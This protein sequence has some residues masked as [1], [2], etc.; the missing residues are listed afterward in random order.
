MLLHEGA[1]A[2]WFLIIYIIIRTKR[3]HDKLES[4][5]SGT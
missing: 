5:T 1:Y 3:E 4:S 2:F